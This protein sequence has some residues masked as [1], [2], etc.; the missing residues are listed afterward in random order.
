MKTLKFSKNSW[1]YKL[2]RFGDEFSERNLS[3]ICS[4]TRAFL[5]GTFL[6]LLFVAFM[7]GIIFIHGEAIG[8]VAAMIAQGTFIEPDTLAG[9]CLMLY[10]A[11]FI[12]CLI[13]YT[14]KTVCEHKFKED[15]FVVNAYHS[16][17]DK[18]CV[19]VEVKDE[20]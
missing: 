11:F 9:I 13:T 6:F 19:R 16:F 18:Y 20:I 2:A 12:L 5:W 17:K 15:N 14:T 8:Y 10:G 4:Y 3:D 7:L 1:H